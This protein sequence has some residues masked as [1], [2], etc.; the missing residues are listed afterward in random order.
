MKEENNGCR[1]VHP[2]SAAAAGVSTAPGYGVI[3]AR[4]GRSYFD[5]AINTYYQNGNFFEPPANYGASCAGMGP[6][7]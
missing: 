7:S 3:F 6:Q 4:A 1:L 5:S 2:R